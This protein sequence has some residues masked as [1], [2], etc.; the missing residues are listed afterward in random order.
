[1][2]LALLLAV[3][4]GL[5]VTRLHADTS[6][7]PLFPRNDPAGEAMLRV[8]ERFAAAEEL[9]VMASRPD[10]TEAPDV[11]PL[12]AFAQ[13]LEREIGA[14][15]DAAAVVESVTYRADE[16]TQDYFKKVLVPN[17]LFYLDDAAFEQAK[18]RLTRPE[19][20]KQF[21]QNEA[22]MA[23]PG[24]A[25]Q[26]LAKAFLQDPLRLHEFVLTKLAASRP[27]QT[28]TGTDAFVSPDG[29]TIIIRISGKRPPSDMEFAKKLTREVDRI[30]QRVNSDGLKIQL[31]GSYAIATAAEAGI[32][33]DMIETVTGSVVL[34]QVLFLIAYR[35]GIR[36]FLLAFGPIALGVLYGFGIYAGVLPTLTPMA[37]VI[38]G[39]LAGMGIDYSIQFISHYDSFRGAGS[40]SREAA[41]QT[42][43]QV[44]PAIFAAWFTSVIGFLAIG[45]SDVPALR[46]FA[47][48]GALGLMGAFLGS[49]FVLPALLVLS[50]RRT[51]EGAPAASSRLDVNGLLEVLQRRRVLSIG[52]TAF[53]VF[54]AAMVL[55]CQR[56]WLP[57][58]S[59]LTVMH[60]R[61]NAP[62]DAQRELAAKFGGSPGSLIV[63]LRA[64]SPAALV[65]LAHQVQRRLEMDAVRSAGV[66][67]AF[68]LAALVP[69]P[70]L[71]SARVAA[72]G[73]EYAK[74]VTDDFQAVASASAFDA[75]RFEPYV[76]FL[77]HLLTRSVAPDV[78]AL[79]EYPTLASAILP[80]NATKQSPPTESVM[81]LSLKGNADQR[82][83]RDRAVLAVEGAIADLPGATLT[84]MAV[85]GRSA[86]GTIQ[87]ELPRLL[88]IAIGIVALYLALHFRHIKATALALVP[89]VFGM[90]TL[91]AFMRVTGQKLN[92]IN[93]AALP[94]LIGIDVDYGI[95]L[96]HLARKRL[97]GDRG[98][99]DDIAP[100]VQAVILCAASTFLGFVS[101]VTTSVPA[102]R[103]LGVAMAIGVGSC[104][105]GTIFLLLPM[106][107]PSGARRERQTRQS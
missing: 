14:S 46:D 62:L 87:R 81:L 51:K 84:G 47:L 6:L 61:P 79:L 30:A 2:L 1:L 104:L 31:T 93:L 50:D 59:D 73:P 68:G 78:T 29:R 63:Y 39:I 90:L 20:E 42:T 35:R 23:A 66:S 21:S 86:E 69:D 103:S 5:A 41:A 105:L 34:L 94:L 97:S 107:V 28:F 101:L 26:A 16:K 57:M 53:V 7:A 19:M 65:T 52:S 4:S 99:A 38:G 74:R 24:P 27:F 55:V 96:V 100:A 44:G 3:A 80:R 37:A 58:E 18:Q 32:R 106:L 82:D 33:R 11:A 54:A 70:A 48:L 85:L 89:T 49:L 91:L 25:A 17:G 67:G 60:P 40:S 92:I 10:Q 36:L 71:A 13:R 75:E 102:I 64:D 95:F 8:L 88:L 76:G 45:W 9:I 12:V 77:N 56:D 22:L 15:S 83:V 43:V 72:T 98:S